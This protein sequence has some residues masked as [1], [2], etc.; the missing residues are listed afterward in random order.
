[1]TL[2][3]LIWHLHPC[4]C[5]PLA[6]ELHLSPCPGPYLACTCSDLLGFISL[7]TSELCWNYRF[8]CG[9][10][11]EQDPIMGPTLPF[12]F[13]CSGTVLLSKIPISTC[14]VVWLPPH[15][16]S[17]KK[18]VHPYLLPDKEFSKSLKLVSIIH[19]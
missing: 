11:D 5:P 6:W 16:P 7:V 9:R 4:S 10:L 18:A 2:T 14:S 19:S 8:L 3:S 1:M 12:L 13:R 15:L 17:W